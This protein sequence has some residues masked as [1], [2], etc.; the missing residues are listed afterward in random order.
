M[1]NTPLGVE[2]ARVEKQETYT[3]VNLREQSL[4]YGTWW[5]YSFRGRQPYRTCGVCAHSYPSRRTQVLMLLRGW[6][7]RPE[8]RGRRLVW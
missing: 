3:L 5:R 2:A 7:W 8:R 6:L 4:I 1:N